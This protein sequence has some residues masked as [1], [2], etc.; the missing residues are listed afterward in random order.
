V[1][2]GGFSTAGAGASA[3]TAALQNNPTQP[4]PA[5]LCTQLCASPLCTH[6]GGEQP[7][8]DDAQQDEAQVGGGGGQGA[9]ADDHELLDQRAARLAQ[10]VADDV[11]GSLALG[12]RAGGRQAGGRQAKGRW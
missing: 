3:P 6:L 11:N 5:P 7:Q 2:G 4:H 1:S 10:G 9:E 8:A 12:L